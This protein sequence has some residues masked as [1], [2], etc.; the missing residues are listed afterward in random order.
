MSTHIVSRRNK[1]FFFFFF[2]FVVEKHTCSGAMQTDD[3][4]IVHDRVT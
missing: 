4:K 2:F 3:I 1:N